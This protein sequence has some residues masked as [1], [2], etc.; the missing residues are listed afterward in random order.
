MASPWGRG[1]YLPLTSESLGALLL[2]ARV[3]QRVKMVHQAWRVHARTRKRQTSLGAATRRRGCHKSLAVR[4]P[5]S[6]SILKILT[7]GCGDCS[8]ADAQAALDK[9]MG[10]RAGEIAAAANAAAR[11]RGI[12]GGQARQVHWV[13]VR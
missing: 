7:R 4:K 3:A 12:V 8:V 1:S 11:G 2:F 5:C 9:T 6:Q 10:A 13:P